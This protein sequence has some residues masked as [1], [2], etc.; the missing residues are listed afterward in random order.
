M[1]SIEEKD[2]MTTEQ[3]VETGTTSTRTQSAGR[4]WS[5]RVW[6]IIILVLLIGAAA[7]TLFP[8]YWLFVTAI[9]PA[10]AT[11]KL[12]PEVI[13]SN[14]TLDNITNLIQLSGSGGLRVLGLEG[15]KMPRMLLWF[16]NTLLLALIS[17]GIHMLFDTMAGY[18]F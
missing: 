1:W 15:I 13:P 11:V 5:D 4:G 10:S 17:T 2:S 14:P 6:K 3:A 12:P 18:A 16:V 8:L 9:T 7:V